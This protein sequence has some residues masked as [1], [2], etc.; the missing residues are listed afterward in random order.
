VIDILAAKGREEAVAQASVNREKKRKLKVQG[1]TTEGATAKK[2]CQ[3]LNSTPSSEGLSVKNQPT[4]QEI[5]RQRRHA[6]KLDRQSTARTHN[7]KERE[8]MHQLIREEAR[9][10][11]I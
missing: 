9:G 3:S 4:K 6:A 1:A 8:R 7:D 5:R 11:T 10:M 2:F